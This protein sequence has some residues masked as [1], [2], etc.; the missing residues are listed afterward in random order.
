MGVRVHFAA[1]RTHPAKHGY[2]VLSRETLDSELALRSATLTNTSQ[3][4]Y[5][6]PVQIHTPLTDIQQYFYHVAP[7]R[8]RVGAS[9]FLPGPSGWHETGTTGDPATWPETGG[10]TGAETGAETGRS[11]QSV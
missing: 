9:L 2:C 7:L 4:T 1:M 5:K 6:V 3:L 8:I 11:Q 10:Q